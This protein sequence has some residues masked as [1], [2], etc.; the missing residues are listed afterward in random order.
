MTLWVILICLN[1]IAFGYQIGT[2][3]IIRQHIGIIS[4]CALMMAMVARTARCVL[5]TINNYID[6]VSAIEGLV[7]IDRE[8][9][10]LLISV[11]LFYGIRGLK[12]KENKLE[13]ELLD[14][15]THLEEARNIILS[16]KRR[17]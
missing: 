7:F 11:G 14:T 1:I 16:L 13:G 9:I 4:N 17:G 6:P 3:W 5:A 8:V 10:T 12:L 15:K 2:I